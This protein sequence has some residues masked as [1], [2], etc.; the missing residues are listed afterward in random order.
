MKKR[1]FFSRR[2]TDGI[3][4]GGSLMRVAVV[5]LGL[6]ACRR[7]QEDDACDYRVRRRTVERVLVEWGMVTPLRSHPIDLRAS[8]TLA[9][10]APS[11]TRVKKG[12]RVVRVDD[13]HLRETLENLRREQESLRLSRDIA[14]AE[15]AQTERELRNH[16]CLLEAQRRVAHMERDTVRAGL[17]PSERRL[18]DI[19]LELARLEQDEAE[20][21]WERQKRWIE[22]GF[23]SASLIEPYRRRVEAAREAVAQAECERTIRLRGPPPDLVVELDRKVEQLTRQCQ[24]AEDERERALELAQL[25]IQ[26]LDARLNRKA[27]A[28]RRIEKELQNTCVDSPVDGIVIVRLYRDWRSGG[29]FSEYKPG[30]AKWKH[31]RIADII[32][33]GQM[34]IFFMLH[35]ADF[36][37]VKTGLPV[38]IRIPAFPHRSFNGHVTEVGGVARDRLDVAPAGFDTETTGVMVFNAAV[39][40]DAGDADVRPGMSALV[41]IIVDPPASRCV[42]PRAAVRST[43]SGDVVRVRSPQGIRDCPVVGRPFNETDYPVEQG[44]R[45]G[46][47]V[48]VPRSAVLLP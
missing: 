35:E 16:L 34:R 9:E 10:V 43:P 7:M 8:G 1:R 6:V 28:I 5:T 26:A 13:R 22:K 15:Y 2:R 19:R 42:V 20:D 45:E 27:A 39:A 29:A 38:R 4:V 3:A 33:Q 37:L 14:V 17:L 25:R 47:I 18:L 44:V 12:D 36:P 46:D 31:D 48:Q 41:E 23:A 21:E 24:R 40:F 11:G 32:E 30:V